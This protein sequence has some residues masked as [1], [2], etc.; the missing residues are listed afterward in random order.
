MPTSH[1]ILVWHTLYQESLVPLLQLNYKFKASLLV[2]WLTF[3]QLRIR[4]LS[5]GIIL[6]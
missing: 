2:I 6:M 3:A 1:L 5:K 4:K